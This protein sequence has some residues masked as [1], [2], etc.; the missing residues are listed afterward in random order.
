MSAHSGAI[1][2]PPVTPNTA[3]VLGARALRPLDFVENP[4][5]EIFAPTGINVALVCSGLSQ[6]TCSTGTVR[7]ERSAHR[8][9]V[10]ITAYCNAIRNR[11]SNRSA[12]SSRTSWNTTAVLVP[13][14]LSSASTARKPKGNPRRDQAS[15]VYCIKTHS[16]RHFRLCFQR[17][18]SSRSH[19]SRSQKDSASFNVTPRR[20]SAS[21]RD[22]KSTR[23]NSSHGYISYAVFCL[24]K[25]KNKI[26]KN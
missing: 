18:Q 8:K 22:R 20:H 1:P 13:R 21:A 14:A 25:K 23:L 6:G 16:P 9:A 7:I 5:S 10:R 2:A 19:P 15:A 4:A 11:L 26:K 12:R 24:K 3:R 17:F